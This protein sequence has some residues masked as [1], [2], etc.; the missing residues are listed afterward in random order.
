MKLKCICISA[1][2]SIVFAF[3][4]AAH[5]SFAMFDRDTSVSVEGTVKRFQWANPHSWI[6]LTVTNSEGQPEDWPIEMGS[7][8]GLIEDGWNPKTLTPG[9]KVTVLCHPLREEGKPG[10]QFMMVTLPDGSHL[11]S[12]NPELPE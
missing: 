4:A 11:G 1:V 5:H 2:A 7:P 3:P 9:M 6:I 8:R 12:E 10:G